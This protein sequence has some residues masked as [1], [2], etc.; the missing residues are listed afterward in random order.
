MRK[1]WFLMG[2]I[3][4]LVPWLLVGCG[5]S[6]EQYDAMVQEYYAA[7]AERDSL[8][9]ELQASV[10]ERDS[11]EEE[12]KSAVAKLDAIK[13]ELN[14]TQIELATTKS[15]LESVTSELEATKLELDSVRSLLSESVPPPSPPTPPPLP[16]EPTAV[17]TL[18]IGWPLTASWDA[19]PEIDGI[20]F[21]L[22]PKD[23]RGNMDE[24]AGVVSAKLWLE[25]SFLEGGGKGNLV[26][27][28]SDIQVTKDNYDWLMGATIYL[29]YKGFQPEMM[30]FGILE[31]TL[32]THDGKSF[33]ARATSVM[34]GE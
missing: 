9:A 6:Q 16:S 1:R 23:A 32:V 13:S 20:E 31:V 17:V 34:L 21:Y 28:W 30:Q 7:V 8:R 14:S 18:D 33:T 4:L 25:R 19:D 11:M 2:M 29:E 15:K 12:P 5:V 27:E 22:T 24:A 3:F 26:Q 10:T